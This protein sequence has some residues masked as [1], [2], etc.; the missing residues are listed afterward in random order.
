M[1]IHHTHNSRQRTEKGYTLLFA[2]ITASLVLSVGVFILGVSKKQFALSV[3]ARE[4]MYALYAADGAMEC[5]ARELNYNTDLGKGFTMTEVDETT[6]RTP[7]LDCNGNIHVADGAFEEISNPDTT[8]WEGTE[9]TQSGDIIVHPLG[10]DG[11]VNPP[12]AIVTVAYGVDARTS[13]DV[14]RVSSRGYNQCDALGPLPSTRTV[15]RALRL[16]TSY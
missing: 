3:A 10:V 7:E 12:C 1:T 16:T 14:V 15:E 9:I 11:Q 2:V 4:S 6:L 5:A 8:L 13:D